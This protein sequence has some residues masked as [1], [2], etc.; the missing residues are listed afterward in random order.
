MKKWRIDYAFR[1]D[2]EYTEDYIVVW[3]M[4]ADKALSKA[5]SI[6]NFKACELGWDL[7]DNRH[8]HDRFMI[9][10]IAIIA[11]ADEEIF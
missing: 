7:K 3:E 6:L 2:G 11:E 5:N 1:K 10:N 9:W 8:Y 4:Y